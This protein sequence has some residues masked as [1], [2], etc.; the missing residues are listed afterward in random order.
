[1]KLCRLPIRPAWRQGESF[2]GYVLRLHAVNALPVIGSVVSA[3]KAIYAATD[4]AAV[5][6]QVGQLL[7][8][9]GVE[10]YQSALTGWLAFRRDNNPG[11]LISLRYRLDWHCPACIVDFGIRPAIWDLHGFDRCFLHAHWLNSTW[12]AGRSVDRPML[13]ERLLVKTRMAE[14]LAE[15]ATTWLPERFP[16]ERRLAVDVSG[17]PADLYVQIAALAFL[18]QEIHHR[19]WRI[20]PLASTTAAITVAERYY[21]EVIDWLYLGPRPLAVALCQN[22]GSKVSSRWGWSPHL[23]RL[24]QVAGW[25]QQNATLAPAH[26]LLGQLRRIAADQCLQED[27]FVA[28]HGHAALPEPDRLAVL[29]PPGCFRQ[30]DDIVGYLQLFARLHGIPALGYGQSGIVIRRQDLP[31]LADVLDDPA[32]PKTEIFTVDRPL[33]TLDQPTCQ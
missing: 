25:L 26:E 7:G 16:V 11:R 19:R 12:W 15:T 22:F 17:G 14:A 23:V 8:A 1:M 6:M 9:I 3:L 18:N 4:A 2:A 27:R 20:G 5:T 13:E 32:R 31:G 33:W 21:G 28:G 29:A 24:H 10:G 30:H